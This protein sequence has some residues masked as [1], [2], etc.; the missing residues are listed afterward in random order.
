MF[1][2]KT[3]KWKTIK[4][5]NDYEVS[6]HGRIKS[7]KRNRELIMKVTND[8]DG[9]QVVGLTMAG[10]KYC[11]KVHR[12]VAEAFVKNPNIKPQVNHKNG[13][14]DFNFYKNLEWVT[15]SENISKAY[16][17]GLIIAKKGEDCFY[18]KLKKK[19]VQNI[20]TKYS[21]GTY[22]MKELGYEYNCSAVN[23]HYI[24]TYKCWK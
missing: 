15:G 24:V 11:K 21:T 19:E 20:R 13:L 14:K 1:N 9:Y 7:L 3:E 10:K 12:L 2:S 6:N 18:S 23:I 5:F 4:D 16:K 8:K 22:S 17:M